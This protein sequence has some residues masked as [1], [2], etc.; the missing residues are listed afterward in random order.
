[1]RVVNYSQPRGLLDTS[2][3][4]ASAASGTSAPQLNVSALL[5]L[6]TPPGV[7][8]LHLYASIVNE[9]LE[10]ACTAKPQRVA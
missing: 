8:S 6:A 5:D 4:G 2:L 1:M 3:F 10:F 9:S 7:F